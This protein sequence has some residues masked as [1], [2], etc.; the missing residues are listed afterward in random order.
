MQCRKCNSPVGGG[1]EAARQLVQSQ[2]VF[3]MWRGVTTLFS[4]CIPAHAAYF[5]VFEFLKVKLGA[6]G[7]DHSP[8]G[9]AAAGAIS[10]LL[11]DSI[12]TPVDVVKQRYNEGTNMVTVV[13]LW[14]NI[15]PLICFVV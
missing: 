11:H 15:F 2:G 1:I 6:D 12:M 3:R 10:T 8:V 13:I 9:A 5:S 14:S 7:P 4:A